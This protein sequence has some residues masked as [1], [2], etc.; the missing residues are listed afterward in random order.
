[1]ARDERTSANDLVV[2]FDFGTTYTGVAYYHSGAALSP[3]LDEND[4]RRTAERIN[5]INIWPSNPAINYAE[6][7]PTIL[8]YNHEPPFWG[9]E[10]RHHH[11]PQITH[12]KLG[13]EPNIG[14]YYGYVGQQFGTHAQLPGKLPVDFA[15]EFLSQ[16]H[17]Y[18]KT[19]C[20]PRQ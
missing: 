5:V 6:K 11:Q 13:L 18:V 16:V 15:T 19:V 3:R 17:Q 8:A 20:F 1:M 2:A 9:G 4:L 10:V 12:F 7:T 14:R